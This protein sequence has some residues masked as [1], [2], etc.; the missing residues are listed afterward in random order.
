MQPLFDTLSR[1]GKK[2]L[3]GANEILFFEGE[4]VSSLL[5]LLKGK[6]RLYKSKTDIDDNECTLHTITA[7]SLIAEMPFFMHLHYPSNAECMQSCEIISIHFD[8][9]CTHIL[10]DTQM[11]SL[12]ITSLCQKI[13]ILESHI[14]AHNQN[15][16][17]RLL[18]YLKSHKDL[19]PTQ[20]QRQIAQNLNV[21]PESLSRTLKML[22]SK[23]IITTTKGKIY[24]L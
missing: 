24:L 20:T 11:C 18:A 14:T 1:I 23:G 7:P 21:S 10:Q 13:Q 3:Y 16:Q 17:T 8:T 19:L 9:F 2:R 12:F 6:V 22:K 5:L 4:S 15:L